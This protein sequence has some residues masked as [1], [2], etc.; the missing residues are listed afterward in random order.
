MRL[1]K[2]LDSPSFSE[3]YLSFFLKTSYDLYKGNNFDNKENFISVLENQIKTETFW[4]VDF[5]KEDSRKEVFRKIIKKMIKKEIILFEEDIIFI[6]YLKGKKIEQLNFVID[7][8]IKHPDFKFNLKESKNKTFHLKI[9]PKYDIKSL[10]LD[11]QTLFSEILFEE[12]YFQFNSLLIKKKN[13]EESLRNLKKMSKKDVLSEIQLA[14]SDD[15][16]IESVI[17]LYLSNYSLDQVFELLILLK[18]QKKN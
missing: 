16:K 14:F 8:N 7:A 9:I 4:K 17:S 18:K 15:K 10:I 2:L 13:K 5:S 11:N 3:E 6:S 12:V 1:D